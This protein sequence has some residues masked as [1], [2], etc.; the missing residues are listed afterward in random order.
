MGWVLGGVSVQPRAE[1]MVG[2]P[3]EL[4]D[5]RTV[6][7]GCV[8]RRNESTFLTAPVAPG[9]SHLSHVS[10]SWAMQMD[11]ASPVSPL[12]PEARIASL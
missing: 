12:V 4:A 3:C 7:V 6:K 1:R 11:H 2:V 5:G 9:G 8:Q 10:V